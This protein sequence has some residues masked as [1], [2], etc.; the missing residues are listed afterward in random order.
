MAFDEGERTET[1][2]PRRRQEAREQGQVARSVE[3]NSALVLLGA[4]T[5]LAIGGAATGKALLTTVEKGLQLPGHADLTPEAVRGL[6]L[7]AMAAFGWAIVPVALAAMGAGL[8]ANLLQVGF[9]ITPQALRLNWGRINPGR[10]LT[11]L[12]SLRGGAELAKALLKLFILGTIAYWTL[13][14]E[15]TRFPQLVQMELLDVLGWELNLGLTLGLRVVF[16]HCVLAA[17]DYGYQRWQYEK[18]IRMTRFEIQEEGRQQEGNPH[19]RARVRQLQRERAMRRMMSAVPTAT[20]VVVNPTHIAVALK[21]DPA[22][23]RAPR[24]VAKGKRRIAERIMAIA[25]AHAVPV[26]Q[27]AP[28]ARALE[29]VVAVGAEIPVVLYRAVAGILAYVYARDPQR[30]AA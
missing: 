7:W 21:Y 22:T 16:A 19:M 4:F 27:D 25:R 8:L 3:V 23:M 29:K 24:V 2:T 18:S 12:L 20:A 17:L 30:Q 1:A 6:L 10:G 28:L 11:Q 13:R 14:P 15:W 9:H 26:I 5:A